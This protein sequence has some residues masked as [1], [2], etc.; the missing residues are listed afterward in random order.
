MGYVGNSLSPAKVIISQK[1]TGG[2]L[3]TVT[4]CTGGH[5]TAGRWEAAAWG[6]FGIPTLHVA[7][8]PGR[9]Y[10]WADG[11]AALC[12]VRSLTESSSSSV[13]KSGRAFLMYHPCSQPRTLL[14]VQVAC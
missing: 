9:E 3:P 7:R 11:C 8:V 10:R 6:P 4:P 1:V 12:R 2:A 14:E 13:L 5:G